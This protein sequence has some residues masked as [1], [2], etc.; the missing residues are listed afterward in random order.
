MESPDVENDLVEQVARIIDPD[1]FDYE[2]YCRTSDLFEKA[3][4]FEV[5]QS[6]A[7]DKAR[8]LIDFIRARDA[9]F[10]S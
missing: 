10:G 7:L 4:D 3:S 6:L 1:A 2:R 8:F 9:D 5:H